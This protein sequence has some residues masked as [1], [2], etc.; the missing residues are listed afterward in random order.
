VE[1]YRVAGSFNKDFAVIELHEFWMMEFKI[2]FMGLKS[3][4]VGDCFAEVNVIAS[5]NPV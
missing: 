1:S 5:G 3:S 4:G 2:S